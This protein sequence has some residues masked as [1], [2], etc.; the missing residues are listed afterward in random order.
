[1]YGEVLRC[2]AGGKPST[3]FTPEG[4]RRVEPQKI[5]TTRTITANQANNKASIY[6]STRQANTIKTS[7]EKSKYFLYKGQ[8]M[9]NIS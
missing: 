4:T 1:M 7:R 6:E 5:S 8:S 3:W 2:Q 9:K